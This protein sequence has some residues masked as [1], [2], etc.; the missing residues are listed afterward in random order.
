MATQGNNDIAA[1][2]L[3]YAIGMAFVRGTHGPRSKTRRLFPRHLWEADV[4][5]IALFAAQTFSLCFSLLF[6]AKNCSISRNL[7]KF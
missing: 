6:V 3:A 7:N 2:L 1:W 5:G 4:D